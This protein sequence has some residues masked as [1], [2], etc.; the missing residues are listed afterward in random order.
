METLKKTGVWVGALIVL[1]A[2]VAIA[3]WILFGSG[4]RVAAFPM[5]PKDH[6]ASWNFKGTYTGSATLVAKANADLAK[7]RTDMREKKYDNYDLYIGMGEDYDL[8]G[9]GRAAYNA[10]NHAIALYP[11]QGLA[12]TD[13]AALMNELGARYTAADAYA[14]AE[15]VQPSVLT[16]HLEQLE[17]LTNYFA[18]DTPRVAAAFEDA[19]KQFGDVAQ[20]LQIEA[21]WLAGLGE[22][23]KA[24]QAYQ[25]AIA[26][27]P[28]RDV[29][30]MQR[31]ITHLKAKEAQQATASSTK[32]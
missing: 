20:V 14:R 1:A 7:L 30:S 23:G 12:Y 16:Y 5:N 29:S 15:A 11:N 19:S 21:S 26:I 8:L 6:I 28:G 13:L 18:T 24:I 31:A 4:S 17:F 3:A 25:R 10:Y 2:L 27:S 22:Y 32:P 9:N